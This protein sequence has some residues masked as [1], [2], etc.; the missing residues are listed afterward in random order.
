MVI[1]Q[2]LRILITVYD[3]IIEFYDNVFIV[4]RHPPI[5]AVSYLNECVYV[6]GGRSNNERLRSVEFYDAESEEWKES[7]QME[8]ERA[9]PGKKIIKHE[10]VLYH[11]FQDV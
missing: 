5:S 7:Q 10:N 3:D 6:S 2:I 9:A 1:N 11:I 4:I 8:R